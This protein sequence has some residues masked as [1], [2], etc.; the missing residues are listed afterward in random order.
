MYAQTS[1]TSN[2]HAP[3]FDEIPGGKDRKSL[4]I[5]ADP[6]VD[7]PIDL[8]KIGQRLLGRVV[9]VGGQMCGGLCVSNARLEHA[10]GHKS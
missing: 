4:Q 2:C 5:A 7:E 9:N 3:D 10:F 8:T 6:S 1:A